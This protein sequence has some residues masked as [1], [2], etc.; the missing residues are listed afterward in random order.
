MNIE[1]DNNINNITFSKHMSVANRY[2]LLFAEFIK[3]WGKKEWQHISQ[4]VFCLI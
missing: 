1:D 4:A 2:S 3:S